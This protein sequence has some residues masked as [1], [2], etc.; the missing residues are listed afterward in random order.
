LAAK[1]D[2]G[3]GSS[4]ISAGELSTTIS[5]KGVSKDSNIF[6]TPTSNTKNNQLFVT[7]IKEEESFKVN[8]WKAIDTDITFDWFIVEER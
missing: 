2:Y 3:T 8:I 5:T 6:I 1:S 7:D 4:T